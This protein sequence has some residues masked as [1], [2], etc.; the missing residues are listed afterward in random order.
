MSQQQPGWSD[1][2][3]PTAPW[4][5]QP[6]YG[7]PPTSSEVQPSGPP[8]GQIGPPRIQDGPV[9]GRPGY[10]VVHGPQHAQPGYG[11]PEYGQQRY[12]QP[13]Y[14]QPTYGQ[15]AYGSGYAQQPSGVPVQIGVVVGYG[16]PA[17][18]FGRDPFTG[19]ALSD[20][21]KVA[22]GLLQ[23]FLGQFG[24]GRFYL[25]HGGIGAA[26]LILFLAGLATA[27]IGIGVI[28]L[29]AVGLWALVDAI[30]IFSGSVRDGRGL[31]LR[32]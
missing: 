6:G 3:P 2:V 1:D 26:Q 16:D 15:P 18:P 8:S 11:Q 25:G 4:P 5:Q 14:G 13:G 32:S 17:A 28:A 24:V 23:L 29:G 19:E 9:H 7:T 21:S 10:A 27:W 31:K 12:G 20:R 30:M 22:G